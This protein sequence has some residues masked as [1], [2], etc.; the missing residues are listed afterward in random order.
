[1]GQYISFNYSISEEHP[2]LEFEIHGGEKELDE[3]KEE[4]TL[5]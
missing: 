1:M 5:R 2:H 4:K 3:P